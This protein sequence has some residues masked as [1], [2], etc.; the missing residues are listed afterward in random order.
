MS[1]KISSLQVENV[2][3][4][5]AVSMKPTESGLTVI[6]GRNG[7]GKTSILDAIAWALGGNKYRPGNPQYDGSVV[8]P[9]IRIRLNNGLLVERKGKNST[10]TVTD[11]SGG[12]A[13]QQLLDS[14]VEQLALDLPRFIQANDK[15]KAET[16]LK[17][18][19]IGDQLL[20][21]ETEEKKVYNERLAIGRVADQK[22]K[23]AAEMP[24]YDGLPDSPVS[25]MDLIRQQQDILAQNGENARKRSR[26]DLLERDYAYKKGVVAELRSKLATA[27]ADLEKCANDCTAAQMD[28]LELQDQ[29][30]AELE[31]A[32]ADIEEINRKIRANLDREKAQED[33]RN[34]TAEYQ[35]LTVQLDDMRAARLAL[36]KDANMPLPDLTVQDGRLLY[37][38]QGWDCMSGAEQLKVATAI[39]RR[40]NPECG[41]VLMDKLE[42]MDRE[43][44]REF[45]AWLEGE[46]L[47]VIATRVST[48]SS[49]CQIIIEDGRAESPEEKNNTPQGWKAGEF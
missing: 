10:L 49:E 45:G 40:L 29:S 27:E 2:K 20:Q 39:I 28:A 26:R 11:P 21:M 41:F 24:Y 9:E 46:G 4:V 7:Q 44:L 48:D 43:T 30:T 25:P 22:A 8:P 5:K 33:A 37:R 17:I 32:I 6:G 18:L 19:G 34:Y 36:L 3:R 31:N 23:F 42:Q 14:F 12:K 47:Q 13:G 35:R 38:G 15:E 1:V 16:L